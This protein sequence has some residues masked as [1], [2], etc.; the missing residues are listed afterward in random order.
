MAQS[1]IRCS[2]AGNPIGIGDRSSMHQSIC[3][4]ERF[5]V[6]SPEICGDCPVAARRKTTVAEHRARRARRGLV[7]VE[8]TVAKADAELVRGVAA[9][10]ADP[11]R[12]HQARVLLRQR[13]APVPKVG[14]KALLASAPLDDI[15]LDRSADTGRE[16]TL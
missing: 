6:A 13:F 1:S 9:A 14:L 8:V 3:R 12:H 15:D 11:D 16:V 4:G 7:R 5:P 2:V 10:L